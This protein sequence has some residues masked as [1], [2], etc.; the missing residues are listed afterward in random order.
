MFPVGTITRINSPTCTIIVSSVQ[1]PGSTTII[2]GQT[3]IAKVLKSR[4][5]S[6]EHNKPRSSSQLP[7]LKLSSLDGNPLE[8]PEWSKMFR[9][10]FH[11]RDIP[12][13]EKMS[14]FV[15]R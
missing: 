3:S 9:A 15:D 8:L 4:S 11:H 10:M 14:K 1:K 5:P 12:D 13:S 6:G 7:K 2:P